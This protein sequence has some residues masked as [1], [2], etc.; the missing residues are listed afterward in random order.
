VG[1]A[2][3][4]TLPTPRDQGDLHRGRGGRIRPQNVQPEEELEA[5]HRSVN[6]CADNIGFRQ[7]IRDGMPGRFVRPH[8]APD[9]AAGIEDLLLAPEKRQEW[10]VRGRELTEERYSW[11][12]VAQRVEALYRAVLEEKGLSADVLAPAA[13]SALS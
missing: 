1:G 7:V 8:D 11:P 13:T 10:A 3:R 12:S 5:L 2:Q 6:V 4:H 9:L